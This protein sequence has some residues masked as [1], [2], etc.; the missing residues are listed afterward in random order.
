MEELFDR[1]PEVVNGLLRLLLR[2]HALG[3][4]FGLPAWECGHNNC[5]AHLGHTVSQAIRAGQGRCDMEVNTWKACTLELYV[6]HTWRKHHQGWSPRYRTCMV[7]YNI[8]CQND[9]CLRH[10][11]EKRERLTFPGQRRQSV[12]R[13]APGTCT[14]LWSRYMKYNCL[15]HL[16]FKL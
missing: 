3:R 12:C 9:F 2:E 5:W 1:E 4:H 14:G 7:A 8:N 11:A 13:V 15:E 6:A 16:R 10:I